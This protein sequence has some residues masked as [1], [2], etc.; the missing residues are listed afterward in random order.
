MKRF[1]SGVA[2]IAA[3]FFL[4]VTA[5][6]YNYP[7]WPTQ[8]GTPI[9]ANFGFKEI[10]TPTFDIGSVIPTDLADYLPE[11]TLGF[12]IRAAS[13]S[14]ILGH[15]DNISV[16]PRVGRIISEGETYIWNGLGGNFT[17]SIIAYTATCSVVID[18][19]WGYG[20]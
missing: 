12:E 17:G 1:V 6:A 8:Q 3:L 16:S 18:G 11:N 15:P 5:H 10:A 20:R 4:A 7:Q 19:A 9:Q 14:F 2:V 13:G